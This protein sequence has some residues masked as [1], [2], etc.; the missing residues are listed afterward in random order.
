MWK[1]TLIRLVFVTVVATVGLLVVAASTNNKSL[2]DKEC[3]NTEEKCT[4]KE[5]K[6]KGDFII[7]E[8]LSRTV[9]SAVQY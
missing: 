1:K 4:Q 3:S 2:P 6:S 9:L 5:D 8:S 7:W